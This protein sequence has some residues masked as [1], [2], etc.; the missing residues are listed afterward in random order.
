VSSTDNQAVAQNHA[1]RLDEKGGIAESE[2]PV[3]DNVKLWDEFT[4]NLYRLTATVEGNGFRDA[5]TVTFGM[6]QMGTKGTQLTVNG[7]ADL[8][9]RHA[10]VRPC[11]P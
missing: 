6:R 7:P 4:P 2:L 5:R 8:P 9:P 1:H 10:R 11:F 3:G